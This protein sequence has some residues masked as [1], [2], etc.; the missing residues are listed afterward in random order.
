MGQLQ[1]WH[2]AQGCMVAQGQNEEIQLLPFS[3]LDRKSGSFGTL[4][5]LFF[6]FFFDDYH[7]LLFLHLVLCWFFPFGF[8]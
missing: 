7:C 1:T 3:L 5:A 6:F 8:L 2:L 4:S